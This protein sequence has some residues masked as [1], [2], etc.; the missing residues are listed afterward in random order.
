MLCAM[1]PLMNTL[2]KF[3]RS[4][5]G[6]KLAASAIAYAQTPQGKKQ[7]AQA[8]EQLAKRKRPR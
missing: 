2:M 3:A 8:R 6:R 5:R 4:R 1:A 7:I